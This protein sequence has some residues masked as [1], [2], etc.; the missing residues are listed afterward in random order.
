ML[1]R[2]Q[3]N[4]FILLEGE[5]GSCGRDFKFSNTAIGTVK[6]RSRTKFRDHM[7]NTDEEGLGGGGGRPTNLRTMY[8]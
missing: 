2:H 7:L 3:K 1:N 5:G 4:G 6:I 8:S